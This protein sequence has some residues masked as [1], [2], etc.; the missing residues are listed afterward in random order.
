[1]K[2]YILRPLSEDSK[3]WSPWYDKSFGFVVRAESVEMART[4]AQ[5][6]TAQGDE[7]RYG[8]PAWLSPEW[9]GCEELTAEGPAGVI[10]NDYR[11]A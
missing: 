9:S 6:S 5:Q 4:I 7:T 10:L 3:P 2:L 8:F 1:M 11:A